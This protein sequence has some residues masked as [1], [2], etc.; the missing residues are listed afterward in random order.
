MR[1]I[2]R[3]VLM[4]F[5]ILVFTNAVNMLSA[6]NSQKGKIAFSVKKGL[7][8]VKGEFKKFTYTIDLASSIAGTAEVT[9][10]NTNNTKRDAHLQSSTWF[11][12]EQ[13]PQ[14]QVKSRKVNA[15][16][17][18]NNTSNNKY[19]G[20]FE[21]TIKGKT[22]TKEIPFSVINENGEKFLKMNF[23]LS[24]DTFDIGG[25]VLDFFVGDKVTVDLKLPF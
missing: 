7:S 5:T 11:D 9:S 21:I 20:V 13:Y 6:Q 15:I 10:I 12:S 8:T 2:S 19:I 14:I 24:L 22:E 18:A 23:T 16:S 17:D 4:I 3:N 25:G 1:T